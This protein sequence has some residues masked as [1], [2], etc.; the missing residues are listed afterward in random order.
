MNERDL[1]MCDDIDYPKSDRR[2]NATC[3]KC[4]RRKC[5]DPED[6]ICKPCWDAGIAK[7]NRQRI[8]RIKAGWRVDNT[9]GIHPPNKKLKG[10]Q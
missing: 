6:E 8:R 9:G 3:I 7:A 1:A 2:K 4:K 5:E 10:K